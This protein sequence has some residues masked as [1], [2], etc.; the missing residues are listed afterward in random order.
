MVIAWMFLALAYFFLENWYVCC[1]PCSIRSAEEQNEQTSMS[2]HL[3][4]KKSLDRIPVFS[5]RKIT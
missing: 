2:K 1:V 3:E 4:G 5:V